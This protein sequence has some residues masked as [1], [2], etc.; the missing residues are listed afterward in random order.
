VGQGSEEL[1]CRQGARAGPVADDS[2]VAGH[3]RI[4]QGRLLLRA[5]DAQDLPVPSGCLAKHG[6]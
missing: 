2:G 1:E 3:I 4:G 6:V 5:V